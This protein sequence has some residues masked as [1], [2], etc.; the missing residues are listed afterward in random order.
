MNAAKA[1][2]IADALSLHQIRD[3]AWQIQ[4]CSAHT[5]EG[6][7]VGQFIFVFVF[8]SKIS[9]VFELGGAWMDVKNSCK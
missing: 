3:R 6:V 9:I 5:K 4:S 1:S 8:F 7:K 2:D